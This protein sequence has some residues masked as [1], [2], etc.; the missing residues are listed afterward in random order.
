MYTIAGK[1]HSSQK[2]GAN[3]NCLG[4]NILES[5]KSR[6][7]LKS[8]FCENLL[9]NSII[10]AITIVQISKARIEFVEKDLCLIKSVATLE[11]K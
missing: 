10:K 6:I 5:K 4:N 3:P 8:L 1:N 11:I 9:V 2:Y 7:Y